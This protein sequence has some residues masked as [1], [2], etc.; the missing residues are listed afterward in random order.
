MAKTANAENQ[1]KALEMLKNSKSIGERAEN[2]IVSAK[3]NIQRDIIDAIIS[4]KEAM[5]DKLF[6]LSDFT[7]E[8]NL[9]AGVER[10]DKDAVEKR[11]THIIDLEYQLKL[12]KLELET[13]QES[14]NKYFGVND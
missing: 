4:K 8:T 7:L 5:E 11:F 3:R 1:V 10:M 2:Y 13:K 14:F 12:L 9:N 6:D